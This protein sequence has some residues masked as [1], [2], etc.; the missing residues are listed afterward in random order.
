MWLVATTLN[1]V[2]LELIIQSL[3]WKHPETSLYSNG[4]N[5]INWKLISSPVEVL[6]DLV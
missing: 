5:E 3:I 4:E 1:S 2:Y 6:Q